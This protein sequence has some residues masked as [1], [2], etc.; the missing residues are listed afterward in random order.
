MTL[1]PKDVCLCGS[2]PRL[3]QRLNGKSW[4]EVRC[5]AARK[6]TAGHSPP[7]GWHEVSDDAIMVWN[8]LRTMIM[9]P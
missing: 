6:K 8:A 2:E 1:D 4:F 5:S 9:E 7:S 3:Y